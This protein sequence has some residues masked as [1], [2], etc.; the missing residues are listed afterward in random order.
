MKSLLETPV[1]STVSTA[2][3]L[4]VW[5]Y[6]SSASVGWR[7]V[8]TQPLYDSLDIG[9]GAPETVMPERRSQ[10]EEAVEELLDRGAEVAPGLSP[11][12]TQAARSTMAG[13]GKRACARRPVPA[14]SIRSV[15]STT[16][17]SL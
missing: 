5:R 4:T 7:S 13:G 10:V 8:S 1:S 15:S 12:T 11:L 9:A 14:S 16:L 17:L 2:T 6:P 3:C